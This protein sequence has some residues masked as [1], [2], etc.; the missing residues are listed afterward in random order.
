M[1]L[2]ICLSSLGRCQTEVIGVRGTAKLPFPRLPPQ[3]L[4][5]LFSPHSYCYFSFQTSFLLIDHGQ[6]SY[7]S[8]YTGLWFCTSR[9]T[10]VLNFHTSILQLFS[11]KYGA[12]KYSSRAIS[13]ALVEQNICA[14]VFIVHSLS[15]T[16][17]LVLNKM[18]VLILQLMTKLQ[19]LHFFFLCL[20]FPNI[21]DFYLKS[22]FG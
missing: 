1:D 11:F 9:R 16:N 15:S 8:F 10:S 17:I 7:P 3:S 14:P 18:K 13:P 20:P 6:N 2:K 19:N 22:Q 4:Y 5:F 12:Q 21:L